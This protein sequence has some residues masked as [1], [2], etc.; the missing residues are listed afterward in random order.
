MHIKV[1]EK[2]HTEARPSAPLLSSVYDVKVMAA[3]WGIKKGSLH[4][5]A[6]GCWVGSRQGV[7]EQWH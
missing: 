1:R 7:I 4:E 3:R 6:V 5:C 2:C